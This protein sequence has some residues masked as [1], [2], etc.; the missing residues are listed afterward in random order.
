MTLIVRT[1]LQQ[2]LNTTIRPRLPGKSYIWPIIWKKLLSVRSSNRFQ[3]DG[4]AVPTGPGTPRCLYG[5]GIPVF[6][7]ENPG[8]STRQSSAAD[9][10]LPSLYPCHHAPPLLWRDQGTEVTRPHPR[11]QEAS[12]IGLAF[13][14]LKFLS[15]SSL[16][17]TSAPVQSL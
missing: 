17:L 7:A 1:H 8:G 16:H 12:P 10:T 13:M 11:Q 3:R 5:S 14:D 9:P 2:S 6:S 4:P 15:G